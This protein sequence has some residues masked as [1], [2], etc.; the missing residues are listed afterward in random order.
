MNDISVSGLKSFHGMRSVGRCPCIDHFSGIFIDQLED[1][2]LDRFSGLRIYSENSDLI[3]FFLSSVLISVL[4]SDTA[5]F[6]GFDLDTGILTSLLFRCISVHCCRVFRGDS[7]AVNILSCLGH[8]VFTGFTRRDLQDIFVCTLIVTKVF[9]GQD[10]ILL[11]GDELAVFAEILAVP[12]LDDEGQG[13]FSLLLGD[14]ALDGLGQLEAAGL[15]GGF[16]FGKQKCSVFVFKEIGFLYVEAAVLLQDKLAV[17]RLRIAFRGCLLVDRVGPSG[18]QAFQGLRCLIGRC[19]FF[20]DR[21]VLVDQLQDSARQRFPVLRVNP[22][23]LLVKGLLRFWLF[24]FCDKEGSVRGFGHIR[25]LFIKTSAF[26]QDQFSVRYL[27]VSLRR[28]LLMDRI[29]P[30]G[31]KSLQDLRCLT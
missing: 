5:G 22:E 15:R 11:F 14:I 23:D 4:I 20:Q 28:C 18:L 17:R 29:S 21:S 10:C 3:G 31:L 19:P 30:S 1:R 27:R 2:A 9:Q 26:F 6:A 25:F 13:A 8:G 16:R 24:R 12:G 7:L